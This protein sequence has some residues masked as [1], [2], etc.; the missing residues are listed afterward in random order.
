MTMKKMICLFLT[1]F[2]ML[3]LCACG[4]SGNA[5]QEKPQLQV[6]FG[7]INTT[8]SY[9]VG[10]AASGTEKNRRHTGLASYIFATCIAIQYGEETYLL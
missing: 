1:V 7:K 10:L 5:E 3:S 6:G 4:G 2:M 8:P 9:S